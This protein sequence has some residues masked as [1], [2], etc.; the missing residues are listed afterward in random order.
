MPLSSIVSYALLMP[1][2]LAHGWLDDQRSVLIPQLIQLQ[3]LHLPAVEDRL[4]GASTVSDSSPF[5]GLP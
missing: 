5:T 2:V 1:K 3:S 4:S